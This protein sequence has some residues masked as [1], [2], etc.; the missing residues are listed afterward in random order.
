MTR[1]LDLSKFRTSLTKSIKGISSG[2]NDPKYWISTGNYT[3]N[4]LISGEFNRGIPLGKF[5]VFAG[6]SGS[7]KTTLLQFLAGIRNQ[8]LDPFTY[9]FLGMMGILV[10]LQSRWCR[11]G[12]VLSSSFQRGTNIN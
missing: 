5:T 1:P 7:G 11:K 4:Y 12:L 2:F 9:I 6:Q 8:H 3:L 10:N